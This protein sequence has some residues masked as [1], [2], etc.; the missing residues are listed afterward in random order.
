MNKDNKFL[1]KD[2]EKL[3]KII[4][5]LND[6]QWAIYRKESNINPSVTKQSYIDLLNRKKQSYTDDLDEVTTTS[7][8]AGINTPFAFSKKGLGNIRSA[9]QNGYK[10][11][12]LKKS[13]Q[14]KN[15]ELKESTYEDE[16]GLVQHNDL[17]LDPNLVTY[18]NTV[19][20]TTE[21]QELDQTGDGKIDVGDAVVAARKAAGMSGKKSK[22]YDKIKNII[23]KKLGKSV[24]ENFTSIK[25]EQEDVETDNLINVHSDFSEFDSRLK[26]S[27]EKIKNDFQ[28]NLNKKLGGKQVIVRS[29]K[30]Y[31]QP[32][33]DYTVNVLDV[34]VDYYYD[35]YVIIINGR[36][37]NKQKTQRFFVKP[38]FKIKVLG[39]SQIK[40]DVS[41][42]ISYDVMDKEKNEPVNQVTTDSPI[43]PPVTN[44]T[45]DSEISIQEPTSDDR[46]NKN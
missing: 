13:R 18:K 23:N 8:V 46:L 33:S 43:E 28:D 44:D 34:N 32:E 3:L 40:K 39:K 20:P 29:S 17:N 15:D 7:A 26:S 45:K 9:K 25:L 42:D 19:M 35:R 11:S 14:Y 4:S 37:K 5:R 12:K 2:I 38:G 24:N 6:R 36:E 31:K 22:M 10:L 21:N 41:N 16:N 27:T 1:I 30:G